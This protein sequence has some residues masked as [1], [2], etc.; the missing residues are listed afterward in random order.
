MSEARFFNAGVE[1]KMAMEVSI[2]AA[3]NRNQ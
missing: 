3:E 2:T 1:V